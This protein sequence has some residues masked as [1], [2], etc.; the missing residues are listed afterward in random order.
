MPVRVRPPAPMDSLQK[1][2]ITSLVSLCGAITVA[3]MVT[4]VAVV[5]W[6][7][8]AEIQIVQVLT[9]EAGMKHFHVHTGVVASAGTWGRDGVLNPRQQRDV[10]SASQTEACTQWLATQ[11]ATRL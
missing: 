9:M 7:G 4:K 5:A 2:T 3:L 10:I 11:S 8:A 1:E 6:S